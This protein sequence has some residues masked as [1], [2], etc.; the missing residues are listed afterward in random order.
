MVLVSL[1]LIVAVG[2]HY[3]LCS[4]ELEQAVLV[5]NYLSAPNSPFELLL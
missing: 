2:V 3:S 1:L 4:A 5:Q